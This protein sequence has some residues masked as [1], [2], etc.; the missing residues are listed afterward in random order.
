ME[1]R[2]ELAS[3]GDCFLPA[4]FIRDPWKREVTNPGDFRREPSDNGS[5]DCIVTPDGWRVPAR[6]VELVAALPHTARCDGNFWEQCDLRKHHGR[7]RQL[8][9]WKPCKFRAK[10]KL[11]RFD[12]RKSKDGVPTEEYTS[13]EEWYG[14]P[15]DDKTR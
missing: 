13:H 12:E 8:P 15:V 5:V 6:C 9:D 4:L 2:C 10:S 11:R 1:N 3:F 14:L 7:I